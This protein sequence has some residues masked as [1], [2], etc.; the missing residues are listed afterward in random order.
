M[1]A[2]AVRYVADVETPEGMVSVD[3]EARPGARTE[4]F[5]MLNLSTMPP[6]ADS[7]PRGFRARLEELGE[8]LLL[9]DGPDARA[10]ITRTLAAAYG[11]GADVTLAETDTD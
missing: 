9:S 10:F 2:G 3:C 8:V 5:F 4:I 1:N 7:G 6:G 11:P